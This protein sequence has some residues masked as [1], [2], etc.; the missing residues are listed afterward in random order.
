[1]I[2]GP[3]LL[4]FSS[5]TSESFLCYDFEPQAVMRYRRYRGS[6]FKP[7]FSIVAQIGKC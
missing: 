6:Y 3:L 2:G 7:T 4:V 5:T 1:M